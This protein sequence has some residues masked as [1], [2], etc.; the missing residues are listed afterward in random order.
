MTV[1]E[2]INRK[3][4][5]FY[6]IQKIFPESQY[7]IHTV[8]LCTNNRL[9]LN[10]MFQQNALKFRSLFRATIHKGKIKVAQNKDKNTT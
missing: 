5:I 3:A 7:Q 6:R 10:K 9:A 1:K 4:I 8:A 2:R